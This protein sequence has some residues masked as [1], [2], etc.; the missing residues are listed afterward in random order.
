MTDQQLS[1]GGE[2]GTLTSERAWHL[3]SICWRSSA[4]SL[5]SG[6]ICSASSW[7]NLDFVVWSIYTSVS[8]LALVIPLLTS[9]ALLLT[10]SQMRWDLPMVIAARL[11]LV[12]VDLSAASSFS[13]SDQYCDAARRLMFFHLNFG[14]GSRVETVGSLYICRIHRMTQKKFSGLPTASCRNI[15]SLMLVLLHCMMECIRL[16]YRLWIS[17]SIGWAPSRSCTMDVGVLTGRDC[18]F[19]KVDIW[20]RCNWLSWV[21]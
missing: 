11:Q 7:L 13:F 10:L 4:A 3:S 15:T 16:S 6:H 1:N 19:L 2:Q 21:F 9:V 8:I 5:Q 14:N 20:K 17:A 18:I 12:K